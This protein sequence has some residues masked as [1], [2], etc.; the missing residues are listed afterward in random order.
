MRSCLEWY[1]TDGL[2]WG[3]WVERTEFRYIFLLFSEK[4][5]THLNSNLLK[6]SYYF[7]EKSLETG[8][9]ILLLE[10]QLGG[11]DDCQRH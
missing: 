2:A 3:H 1:S 4:Q 9:Y 6:P 11:P 10:Q 8:I 7:S 5:E